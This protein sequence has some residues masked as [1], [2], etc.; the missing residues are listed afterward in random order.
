MKLTKR[1]LRWFWEGLIILGSIT[2]LVTFVLLYGEG[3]YDAAAEN[4]PIAAAVVIALLLLGMNI[5][6]GWW[7]FSTFRKIYRQVMQWI[8]AIR[9][10]KSL[11]V[12]IAS[13]MEWTAMRFTACQFNESG[14]NTYVDTIS[15]KQTELAK[16]LIELDIPSPENVK[17]SPSSTILFKWAVFLD[18]L[19]VLAVTGKLE[20]ARMLVQ[21]LELDE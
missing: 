13:L 6:L 15:S 9:Q 3:S 11:V 8:K 4:L 17:D 14:Y 16:K 20:E 19:L 21:R 2:S 18:L 5:A 12:G 1:L 10:L 7:A